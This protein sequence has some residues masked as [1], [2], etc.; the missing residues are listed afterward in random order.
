[1]GLSALLKH[2]KQGVT[3]D[4]RTDPYLSYLLVL[5][6]ILTGFWFWHR[7]PGFATHDAFARLFD[8][9]LA[10]GAVV[11]DGE[12]GEFEQG[13]MMTPEYGA[14]FYL[15]GIATVPVFVAAV[16]TGQLDE[17]AAI[18]RGG[19]PVNRLEVWQATPV[20]MLEWSLLVARLLVVVLAVGCV[21][22]TYCIGVAIRDRTTGRLAALLLTFTWGFLA[23]VHE[24][25]EDVPVLFFV[26]LAVVLALRYAE[27][28]DETTFLAGCGA[29][30][31]AI[32]FKLTGAITVFVLGA[33]YLLHARH[34][35]GGWHD[36]LVRPRLLGFGALI[37]VGM[38]VIG[39]PSV[40][41]EGLDVL[42]R[43]MLS[44]TSGTG[45]RSEQFSSIWWWMTRNYLDGFG[46][47]LFIAAIGGVM[48][49][50]TLLRDQDTS[51]DGVALL[52]VALAVF[53]FVMS[54]R[55]YVRVHHLVPTFPLFVLLVAAAL[56]WLH[57]RRLHIA[58]ALVAVLVVTSGA[59]AVAGDL[60][61]A[62]SP[63]DETRAWLATNAPD[64]S[65][66]E[67]YHHQVS[68]IVIPHGMNVSNY[69]YE[70]VLVAIRSPEELETTRT[71]WM[72]NMPERCPEYVQLG[73][74]NLRMLDPETPVDVSRPWEGYIR[75][76]VQ[77]K[78]PYRIVAEFGP[79]PPFIESRSASHAL[80]PL[81]RAGVIPW[82]VNYGDEQNHQI[83]Q[84]TMILQR[85]GNCNRSTG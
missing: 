19:N 26:L 11:A 51:T 72:R 41:V 80:P 21:Y 54:Q 55:A 6:T 18:Y 39:F 31:V 48:G 44:V 15:Y 38:I 33:A 30:G 8:P 59:Y 77:G 22:L 42:A 62:T 32:A 82:T 35:E 45:G 9:M 66:I 49:S 13:V 68:D 58:R 47:P 84:Y 2:A 4:L 57:D 34:A 23:T 67:V 50:V 20:W 81:L 40:L 60:Q 25:G 37:G 76:L 29:G 53:F 63:Q 3:S 24:V 78:Y 17:F 36:A 70:R 1:M 5:A 27:T 75:D 28:G 71:K 43:R 83:E 74:Y 52:W 14:T 46:L 61:Y 7:I 64:D 65:T 56:S 73:Y 10:I 79:R 16:L 85:T 69:G 12:L